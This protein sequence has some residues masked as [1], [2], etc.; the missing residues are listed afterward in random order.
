MKRAAL[1]GALVLVAG[2]VSMLELKAEPGSDARLEPLNFS[3]IAGWEADD[4][5]AA[6]RVFRHSCRAI[7]DAD[8]VL[9]PAVSPN[10]N[11]RAVCTAALEL[12]DRIEPAEARRFFE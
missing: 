9:R 10:P 7:V 3:D 6:F 5:A 8:P 12:P 4:H 11:L 1:A 2:C